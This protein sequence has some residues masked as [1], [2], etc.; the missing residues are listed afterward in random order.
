MSLCV[1]WCNFPHD[2]I[3]N[4]EHFSTFIPWLPRAYFSGTPHICQ[5]Q[6]ISIKAI[7]TKQ[8]KNSS[9]EVYHVIIL[10]YLG[11]PRC[12]NPNVVCTNEAVRDHREFGSQF[13]W[14]P[15]LPWLPNASPRRFRG[16]QR[17]VLL[18][19][20][21]IYITYDFLIYYTVNWHTFQ[22]YT[23]FW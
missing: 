3:P 22:T 17:M 7:K 11:V 18:E 10:W 1:Y 9:V 8:I 2:I 12:K 20:I 13:I 21:Y 16:Y 6:I 5:T 19:Y 23:D 14:L 15:K 4:K